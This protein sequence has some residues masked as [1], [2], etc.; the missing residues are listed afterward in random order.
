A[1]PILLATKSTLPPPTPGALLLSEG[2]PAHPPSNE[3]GIAAPG[4]PPTPLLPLPPLPPVPPR[5]PPAPPL[6]PVGAVNV[7]LVPDGFF[8]FSVPSSV[9]VVDAINTSG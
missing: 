7:Q 5:L 4:T 2:P 9:I 1:L 6:I 3:S 8:T